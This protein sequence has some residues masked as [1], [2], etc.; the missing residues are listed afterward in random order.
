[1]TSAPKPQAP[2]PDPV[3]AVLDLF[4]G[5]LAE[6]QFPDLDRETLREAADEVERRRAS[7]SEALETVQAARNS[8]E[9]GQGKLLEQVRRAYA[10]ASVYAEGD[11]AL[12]AA[13]ADIKLDARKLAPKKKRG[14]PRKGGTKHQTSL[15][16]AEDAA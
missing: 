2:P 6:I 11:E 1:M 8:L 16:V 13:L 3:R 15:S 12:T 4:D 9:A 5:P 7:L 14:R 10:Y